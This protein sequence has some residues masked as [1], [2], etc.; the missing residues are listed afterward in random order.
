M[1]VCFTVDRGQL[2]YWLTNAQNLLPL[3]QFDKNKILE[4][5]MCVD[6]LVDLCLHLMI[7]CSFIGFGLKKIKKIELEGTFK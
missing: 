4:N 6:G 5:V 2:D 3:D 1:R 7:L